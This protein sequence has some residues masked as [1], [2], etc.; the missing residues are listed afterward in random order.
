M[1]WKLLSIFAVLVLALMACQGGNNAERGTN[2]PNVNPTTYR[3][4]GDGIANDDRDYVMERNADRNQNRDNRG[5]D[6]NLAR[7]DEN[8]VTDDNYNWGRDDNGFGDDNRR[9][10]GNDGES[11]YEIAEEA[12]D[13][14]TNEIDEIDNAYVLTMRNNAYVA[15]DLDIDR[16]NRTENRNQNNG[17]DNDELSDEIKDKI[18]DIVRSV[19]EDIDNVY[20]STNPDFLDLT[21]NYADDLNQGRPIGGFFDQI[22][23]MLDRLFPENAGR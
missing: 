4:T 11:R 20:V 5:R 17:Y 21:T 15:A 13:K 7:N 1:K 9:N 23:T 18:G 19:D 22:G 14:I 10:D 16:E 6:D 3:N 12:A 8:R 2:N